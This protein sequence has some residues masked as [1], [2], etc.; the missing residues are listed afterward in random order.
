MRFL[1]WLKG[2]TGVK[3]AQKSAEA[4][5]LAFDGII[6]AKVTKISKHPN[7][8][9]LQLVE[10]IDGKNVIAPIVCGAFNFKVGDNVALALPG[11]NIPKNIHSEQHESFTLQKAKIRGVESQG[12]IC[13]AFELGLSQE[14]GQG[15]MVL[16]D[17][18]V[19]GSKFSGEM[20]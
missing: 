19:L 16:K 18:A 13:A 9:R 15:I 5:S 12:M 14:V 17:S 10:L 7:A 6:V 11:A 1:K 8:D 2:L 3:P 20:I 4:L